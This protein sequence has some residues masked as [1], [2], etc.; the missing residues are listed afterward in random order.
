MIFYDRHPLTPAKVTGVL[1]I[2]GGWLWDWKT[3]YVALAGLAAVLVFRRRGGWGREERALGW[4][5]GLATLSSLVLLCGWPL[6]H[7]RANID[8]AFNR[9]VLH[10]VPFWTILG[11]SR[12]WGTGKAAMNDGTIR[13][14]DV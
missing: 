1:R 8:D 14:E 12:I 5:A 10:T 7:L 3:T 9:M 2:L 13:E 6:D 4:M 11:A